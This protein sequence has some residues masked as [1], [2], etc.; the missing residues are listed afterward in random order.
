MLTF[1]EQFESFWGP[2][3]LFGYITVRAVM[4]GLFSF[5]LAL[6]LG[7]KIIRFLQNLKM[8]EAGRSEEVVGQLAVLHEGKKETPTMGGLILF[9]SISISLL[10]FAVPNVYILVAWFVYAGLTGIGF[11][12]DYRKVSRKNSDGLSGRVK[13]LGQAVIAAIAL[14]VFLLHPDTSESVRELWV[15]FHKDVVV[16]SMP[17]WILFPFLFLILAGS[18]NAI[19][20]TDGIDGLAIGCT[21]TSAM[22]FGLMAYFAGNAIISDYLLISFQPGTGELAVL[23]AALLGASLGF[24]WYNAHPAEVFMGD[25]GS[26][27]LGGLIGIVAFMIHQP[28]TLIIVGGIFVVEA[29]SVILQV[30]SYKTRRKRIFL[31]APIHHHFELR[32]WHENK[33][34]IRFW[35]ISLLCAIAGLASLRLR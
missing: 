8:R 32:G 11:L 14:T 33:V 22:A 30:G 26:L 16:A 31:M 35:I 21:V 20:L 6:F 4:A 23:C 28:F 1:L 25:T 19:N 10:L 34:V 24:L 15:P 5:V 29:V 17:I 2:L 9:A 13:L 27:A 7:P 3:R 18:S 12:D